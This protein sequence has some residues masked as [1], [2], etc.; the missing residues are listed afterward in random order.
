[1]ISIDLR[2]DS[3]EGRVG[4]INV[5]ILEKISSFAGNTFA[6]WVLLFTIISFLF[7]SGFSWIVPHIS[8]LLGVIMF[9]M[10]LTLTPKDFKGIIK[11]PKIVFIAVVAQYTI[12]P[13]LAYLLVKIFQLPAE[14]AVGVILVG[15]CPG[16]TASNVM[17]YLAKG[18]TALSVSATMVS[19]LL[20]P[21]VTPALTLLLASE[22][23]SVSFLSMFLSIVKVVLLPII[24]GIVVRVLF[25]QQVEQSITVL[26]LISV[27]GIVAVASAVV[28]INT[29]AII[30]SGLIIFMVVILHNLVGLTIGFLLAK[31]CK[32]DYASQKTIAIEV[33][34]QNSGLASQ[35]AL[36]FFSAT[37]IAAVPSAIFS[38]WHNISGPILSTFWSKRTSK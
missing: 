19:T 5:R 2:I 13:L 9:G 1:M 35:L 29:E 18:N 8:L 14:V 23:M 34:M 30:T 4:G 38:V 7:P 24:L 15:C 36:V 12:M 31:L 26:P 21:I 28:S 11:T 3:C 6:I 20:A 32:L 22:W 17:V 27:I 16:G 37:P 25:R 10:G 33:G